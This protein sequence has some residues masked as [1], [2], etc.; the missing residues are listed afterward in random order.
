MS[1]YQAE[2]ERLACVLRSLNIRGIVVASG[3]VRV[4]LSSVDEMHELSVRYVTRN[5]ECLLGYS[6][7]MDDQYQVTK[8]S[9]SVRRVGYHSRY[10]DFM[11][12][13][14]SDSVVEYF[15]AAVKC[16]T[17]LLDRLTGVTNARTVWQG[18]ILPE[19]RKVK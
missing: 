13:A 8:D 5:R 14:D 19:L 11:S 18:V 4:T 2:A 16:C 3:E 1:V 9:P 17:A 7:C 15:V 12:D 10:F 6:A